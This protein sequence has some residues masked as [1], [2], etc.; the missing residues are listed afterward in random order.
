MDFDRAVAAYAQA[1]GA[2]LP[3]DLD[4]QLELHLSALSAWVDGRFDPTAGIGG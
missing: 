4:E 3:S 2:T 1:A